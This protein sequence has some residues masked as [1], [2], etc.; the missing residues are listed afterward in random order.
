MKLWRQRNHQRVREYNRKNY[1]S[2]RERQSQYYKKKYALH[3][4]KYRKWSWNKVA[5]LGK[6]I[7]VGFRQQRG[8]CSQCPNN[9]YDGTCKLTHMHHLLY[10]PIMIWACRIE[11]CA[12]CHRKEKIRP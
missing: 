9:V 7:F 5:F 12:S 8:H 10:V 11:L 1:Y 2:H 4:E 3:P 6:Q